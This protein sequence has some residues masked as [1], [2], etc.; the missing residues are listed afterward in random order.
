MK[1]TVLI[2]NGPGLADLGDYEGN[3]FSTLTLESIS[4]DCETRCNELGIDLEFRQTE[5]HDELFRWIAKDS[6]DFDGVI[7]NP[8][9]RAAAA[10]ETADSYRSA[11][12]LVAQLNKPVIEVHIDNIYRRSAENSY[13]R[14][15]P[16][17]DMGFICG[18]G[19]LGYTLAISSLARRFEKN[20]AA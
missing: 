8:A 18:F 10:P 6:E 20:A 9:A 7:I 5:D 11:I 15:E 19:K 12:H 2:L 14:H 17:G 1:H 3:R 16:E 4:D 13:S